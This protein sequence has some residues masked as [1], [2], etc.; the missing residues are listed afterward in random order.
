MVCRG[1]PRRAQSPSLSCRCSLPGRRR[2]RR[3]RHLGRGQTGSCRERCTRRAAT[4]GRFR[5]RGAQTGSGKCFRPEAFG[6]DRSGRSGHRVCR[7]D[8]DSQRRRAGAGDADRGPPGLLWRVRL[9]RGSGAGPG[10][11]SGAGGEA[12]AAG[13]VFAAAASSKCG[14]RPA[15]RTADSAEEVPARPRFSLTRFLRATTFRTRSVSARKAFLTSLH[16]GTRS[17]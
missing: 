3:P 12:G 1:H 7:A 14:R 15:S 5:A 17:C 13:D 6:P 10:H 2:S 11:R 8:R 16:G 9:H 4:S